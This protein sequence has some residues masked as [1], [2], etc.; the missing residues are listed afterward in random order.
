MHRR[1]PDGNGEGP[2]ASTSGGTL[3]PSN[4]GALNIT[5][6]GSLHLTILPTGL[7]AGAGDFQILGGTVN[8][9]GTVNTLGAHNFTGGIVNIGGDY[10]PANNDL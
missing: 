4:A 5:S 9:F 2:F 8:L 3:Q 10:N 7:I 1:A 6:G